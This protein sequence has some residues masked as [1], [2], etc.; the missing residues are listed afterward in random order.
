MKGPNNLPGVSLE[1]A[2]EMNGRDGV[3]I[4]IHDISWSF[5]FNL[6]WRSAR[7]TL[8]NANS[9]NICSPMKQGITSTLDTVLMQKKSANALKVFT[10]YS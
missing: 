7:Q 6:H 3:Y 1:Q 10:I 2:T 5:Q 9:N 4:Q 8:C